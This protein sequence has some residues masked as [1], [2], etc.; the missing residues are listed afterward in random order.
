MYTRRGSAMRPPPAR[1]KTRSTIAIAS[2][3]L[4]RTIAT[5][6]DPGAVAIAAMVSDATL[7]PLRRA[8]SGRRGRWFAVRPPLLGDREHVVDEPVEHEPRREVDEHDREHDG[9]EDHHHP[10]L[11][12]VHAGRRREGLLENHASPHQQ[13]ENGD[14]HTEQREFVAPRDRPLSRP[15]IALV[16]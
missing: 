5:P 15:R 10:L 13:H 1:T 7:T 4:T 9:H 8:D 16:R 6:P 3:P 11:R 14:R 2:G 12:R